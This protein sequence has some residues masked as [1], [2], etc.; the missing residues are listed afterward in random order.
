MDAINRT[1]AIVKPKQPYLEWARTV[2]DPIDISLEELR[3][4]CTAVLLPDVADDA[5]AE[6]VV[7]AI[8]E[9]LFAVELAAWDTD[10][11][12]W[13]QPRDDATFRA[14]FDIE[15]HS[16]VL[17]SVTAPIRHERYEPG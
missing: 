16:V 17:D 9:E 12:D 10:E 15:L 14:W 11:D 5:E 6:A 8:Y 7:R 4:D 3:R 13:P 2:P 1:V